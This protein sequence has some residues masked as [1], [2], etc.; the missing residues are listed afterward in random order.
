ML[1][2]MDGAEGLEGVYVLAATRYAVSHFSTARQFID[3]DTSRPDLIDSALLRPGRLDKAVLCNMPTETERQ[4]V[5][6]CKHASLRLLTFPERF[7]K[8]S[9]EKCLFTPTSI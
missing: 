3:C 2:Q 5:P 1:T 8:P 4:E 9:A 6:S 7:L